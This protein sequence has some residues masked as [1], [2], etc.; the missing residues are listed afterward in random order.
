MGQFFRWSLENFFFPAQTSLGW[1]RASVLP[2][3]SG[4]KC[5]DS[6]A[7]V[8][9]V[10]APVLVPAREREMQR[11]QV[12]VSGGGGPLPAVFCEPEPSFSL[13]VAGEGATRENFRKQDLPAGRGTGFCFRCE[14]ALR[15][16]APPA[17][18]FFF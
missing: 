4:P 3:G 1:L 16:S 7:F 2:G 13:P 17:V 5:P 12:C 14:F 8:F 11:P 15:L 6:F 9:R 18:L 10:C